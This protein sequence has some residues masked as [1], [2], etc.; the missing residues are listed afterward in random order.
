M[1][2]I[3]YGIFF[4]NR[5]MHFENLSD[6][7]SFYQQLSKRKLVEIPRPELGNEPFSKIPS[8]IQDFAARG[9]IQYFLRQ[10]VEG[11]DVFILD[12]QNALTHYVQEGVDVEGLVTQISHHHA[13]ND[14]VLAKE[15]FNMP[16]FF[17][18]E[19]L[20]GQLI[21]LPFGVSKEAY[22]VEF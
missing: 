20:K 13:F 9:A 6:A 3:R 10:R 12:E 18:L 22:E 21:A 4:N 5:G 15:Q 11:L 7:K 1:G 17:K 8:V 2:A 19:R 14:S 16:Q